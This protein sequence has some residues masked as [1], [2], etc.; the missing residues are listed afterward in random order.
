M[1]K[2]HNKRWGRRAIFALLGVTAVGLAACTDRAIE[3]GDVSPA[4]AVDERRTQGLPIRPVEQNRFGAAGDAAVNRQDRALAAPEVFPATGPLIGRP[5]QPRRR[6]V[7]LDNGTVSLNFANVDIRE[8]IGVVLGDTLNLNYVID[9]R[10][11]GTV[12]A[13]TAR[14][15]ARS[16]VIPALE[17]I[18]A[19]SGVALI[20]TGG[21]FRVV[22]LNEAA[23]GISSLVVSPTPGDLAQGFGTHILPL[24]FASAQSMEELLRPFVSSAGVNLS[25]S[26]RKWLSSPG[27]LG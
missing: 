11:Q 26:M 7:L 19:L 10:I 25:W 6:V 1:A 3:S 8:V 16:D 27:I 22:P 14:P 23:S 13:R 20:S 17:N 9:S 4:A 2:D 15:I 12:T 5:E 24:R 21:V 18:L